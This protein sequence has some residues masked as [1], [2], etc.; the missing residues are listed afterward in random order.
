MHL[1]ASLVFTL[2]HDLHRSLDIITW[3]SWPFHIT[4]SRAFTRESTEIRSQ[5]KGGNYCYFILLFLCCCC[6][7]S[8]NPVNF[9][10]AWQSVYYEMPFIWKLNVVCG[11]SSVS[12]GPHNLTSHQLPSHARCSFTKYKNVKESMNL[13]F[14]SIYGGSRFC[15]ILHC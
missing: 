15:I 6:L 8:H 10:E 9:K 1:L 4:F 7:F 5:V 2:S 11:W 12:P 13:R 14:Q 3:W